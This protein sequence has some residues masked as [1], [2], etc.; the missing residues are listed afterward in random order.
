MK[1]SKNKGLGV[2][3]TKLGYATKMEGVRENKQ[4][5]PKFPR[6]GSRETHIGDV[7]RPPS[8][9]REIRGGQGD[10]KVIKVIKLNPNNNN[11]SHVNTKFIIV[12]YK[13][14]L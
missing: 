14:K 4:C 12:Q 1:W 6:H 9:F 13:S 8:N 2:Y 11:S 10:V 7:W 3:T 5:S